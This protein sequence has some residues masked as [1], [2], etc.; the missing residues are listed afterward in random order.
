MIHKYRTRCELHAHASVGVHAAKT[1]GAAA[2]ESAGEIA[3]TGSRR[4]RS[5]PAVAQVLFAH[6][7]VK[8]RMA[9]LT[10]K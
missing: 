5:T 7:I 2:R 8:C 3:L 9:L 1:T 10:A 4:L 6:A